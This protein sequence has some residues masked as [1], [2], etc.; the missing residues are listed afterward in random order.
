MRTA[1]YPAATALL[2]L[3]N[4]PAETGVTGAK[5]A[6]NPVAPVRSRSAKTSN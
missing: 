4:H 2:E 5:A 1:G 3:I 6:C